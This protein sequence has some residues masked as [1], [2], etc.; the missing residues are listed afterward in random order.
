MIDVKRFERVWGALGKAGLLAGV[1]TLAAFAGESAGLSVAQTWILFVFSCSIIGTL[2]YWELRLSFMFIGSGILM[3]IH[4]VNLERFIHHASLD[5]ILF[6]VGM[7]ILV[8]MMKESGLFLYLIT[9]LLRVRRLSGAKLFVMVMLLSAVL[10]GFIGEVSS[11]VL[12]AAII[13]DI[14]SFLEVSPVPLML[15]SIFAT[16]I[17]SASTVIGN[18]IGVL[19]AARGKLSFEDFIVHALPVSY[20]VL[21]MIILLLLWMYRGYIA[22][23]NKALQKHLG[24]PEFLSLISIPADS[25]TR[26]SSGIFVATVAGIALHRRVELALG[27]EENTM[28]I[29]IP[30][31]AAGFV[32]LYRRERATHYIERE[33]EWQSLLFFMFLFAQA[34][35]IQVSGVGSVLAERMFRMLGGRPDLLS[36]MVLFSSG[37]FSSVLDNTVVVASYLP[38][39]NGLQHSGGALR[40]DTLYWALLFGACYGGNITT[41]GSTANIVALGLMEK[42]KTLRITFVEWLKIGLVV[43]VVS[44]LVA[45]AALLALPMYR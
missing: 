12:V 40:L 9:L 20:A 42:N 6:L 29:M 23:I 35:V 37:V 39:I 38:I 8:A 10:S 14:C 18:P 11:I 2:L 45:F 22:T 31:I 30:V 28:L 13:T 32:M 34:G 25:R 36:G 41:I 24:N 21:L 43:G 33:V 26:I 19:I 44:M 1:S 7:M 4:A 17:G 16:N 5:V 3:L 27:M 15:S